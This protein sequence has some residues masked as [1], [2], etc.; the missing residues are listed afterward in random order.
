[1]PLQRWLKLP[2][3]LALVITALALLG[4]LFGFLATFGTQTATQFTALAAQ[5][6]Q[7]WADTRA[8]LDSW[9]VG[10][11]LLSMVDGASNGAGS[12][13]LM[14]ALPI[15]GGVLGGIGNAALIVV[16][17]LYLAA[18][19]NVYVNG[20][21]RLLPPSRRVRAMFIL[22]AAGA[23]LRK[24]LT[25]MTLDMVFYGAVTGFGLWLVGAPF[26]FP[27]AV[28]AGVSVFVPYIGPLVAMV[29]GLLLALSVSPQL[30]LYAG[31][32]YLIAHELEVNVSLPLLQ[33]WTV[34]MPP[35]VSMLAIVAFGLLFGFWG[36]LLATPMAVVSMTVIRMAYVEDFLEKNSR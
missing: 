16:I 31:I 14:S 21:L 25:A 10:R 17:G 15:A 1:V 9:P 6:P 27:L 33:R 5:L 32:V 2:H 23:D 30:A 3:H 22:D 36:V 4:F 18:D 19:A 29:P 24:W 8:W 28:L 13:T 34:H 20:A 26:P 7:A 12:T 11:W 35:A